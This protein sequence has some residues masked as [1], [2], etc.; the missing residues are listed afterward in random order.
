MSMFRKSWNRGPKGADEGKGY[1]NSDY[2]FMVQEMRSSTGR[3]EVW[4]LRR[5]VKVS[6]KENRVRSWDNERLPNSVE[7]L[8]GDSDG[9]FMVLSFI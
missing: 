7:G 6:V 9:E 1:V 4:V 5:K 3:N 8:A 2:I